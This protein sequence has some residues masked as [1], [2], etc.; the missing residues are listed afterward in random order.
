M[1]LSRQKSTS[2][3]TSHEVISTEVNATN[4][5][6][7]NSWEPRDHYEMLQISKLLPG[8]GRVCVVGR[9]VNFY[10]QPTPNRM[11][12]AAKGCLKVQLRD[13]SGTIL[14]SQLELSS[15]N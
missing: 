9:V 11:P 3:V 10:E 7:L 13:D 1:T 12:H 4:H 6:A 5:R 14:V 8:S 15:R 2:A